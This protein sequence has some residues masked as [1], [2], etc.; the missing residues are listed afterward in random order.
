MIAYLESSAAAKLLVEEHESAELSSFLD[1]LIEDGGSLLAGTILETELRRL[2]TRIDLSQQRVADVLNRVD[3]A[4][5]DGDLHRE[6]GLLPARHLRS[7]DAIH[8]AVA[9]ATNCD[10]MLTYD[11]RQ[12][13]AAESVGL[14]TTD[15]G[16]ANQPQ[17]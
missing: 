3:L 13:V 12:Q 5:I 11:H 10:L 4:E 7:L 14:E 8:I 6:A 17:D 9:R 16:R 1:E 15:P 2:A